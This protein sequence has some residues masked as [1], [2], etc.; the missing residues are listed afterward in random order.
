MA[1]EA[2][3]QLTKLSTNAYNSF[4]AL[5]A[6]NTKA[7][8]RLTRAQQDLIAQS[9]EAGTQQ[10]S[11]AG[12]VSSFQDILSGQTKLISAQTEKLVNYARTT[13]QILR[14]VQDELE[15]WVK[16]VTQGMSSR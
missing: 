16:D 15:A 7:L 10:L 13:T 11:M 14:E 4:R 12:S 5:V 8:E 1:T 2:F 6:I 3:E 9:M